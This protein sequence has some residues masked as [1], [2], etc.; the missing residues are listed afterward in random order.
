MNLSI[1]QCQHYIHA[2]K[3]GVVPDQ[4]LSPLSVG[5]ADILEEFYRC[6]NGMKRHESYVKF[7]CGPYGSG[8]SFML[9]SI[10]Q[11]A[12]QKGFVTADIQMGHH[13]RLYSFESVYYRIMHHLSVHQTNQQH[14]SFEA[15]FDLWI[16]QKRKE[17]N[18]EKVSQEILR[19]MQ[20]L[21]HYNRSFARAFTAYL[22]ARINQNRELSQ[23]IVSW[24][25]G[26]KNVPSHLKAQFDV[27]GQID[28]HNAVDFLRAFSRLVYLL[29]YNGLVILV[30]E[31]E[32]VMH[33]RSDLRQISYDNLRFLID[34][35]YGGK[36]PHCL[37][38]FAGT[39]ELFNHEKKGIVTHEALNQ[40][41][42]RSI[43]RIQV[44]GDFRDLRQP[45]ITLD[46]FRKEKWQHLTEQIVALYQKS[47][48]FSPSINASSLRN[49]TMLE[50][51]K[52]TSHGDF[53][54]REYITKLI[55]VLDLM[56]QHP[57]KLNL[58]Q[59]LDR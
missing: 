29:G 38:V 10:K 21:N 9:T 51:R 33:E 36:L 47:Y 24:L 50:L 55:E 22:R 52:A 1:E 32:Y 53:S 45:V 26:E 44:P 25:T 19:L 43:E 7:L 48:Q 56:Q 46:P 3:N 40:R 5:R 59:S 57:E 13:T 54:I 27:V 49:W 28:K 31:L 4:D 18:Q 37:F 39:P 58:S 11:Q 14:T 16:S 30:D 2:L 41:L 8:K 42:G 23:A 20:A 12:L 35:S 15:I 17:N 6:L 34:Q